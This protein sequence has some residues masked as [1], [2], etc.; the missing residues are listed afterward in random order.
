MRRAI[1]SLLAIGVL[2]ILG[3]GPAGAASPDVDLHTLRWFVHVDLIDAGAGRD[4]AFWQNAIDEAVTSGNKLLE[5]GQGPFDTECCTRINRTVAVSTFGSPG[6]GLDTVNSFAE[7]S[8]IA[9]LATSGSN[10]Y[11]VDSMTFCGSMGAPQSSPVGCAQ[12]PNCDGNGSDDPT[13]WM[14]VTVQSFDSSVLSAV[15]AHERGH[16]SCLDH[17]AANACQLMQASVTIPGL[18]GCLTT[19]ECSN[20]QAGRTTTSSGLTCGCHAMAGGIEDDGTSCTEVAGG[21]CSGGVCG[22]AT[23]DAGVKLLS[24]AAPGSAASGGTTDDAVQISGLP[25][26]WVTLGPFAPTGDEVK[27]MA[28]A[29]DADVLYGVVPT[30]ADDAIVTLDTATGAILATVGSIANGTDEI[31]SMAYDPGSTSATTDD[32]L[33]VLEV[34]IG[35][36]GEFRSIDPASPSTTT[37]LGPLPFSSANEFPGLAYDSQQGRLFA[38]SLFNSGLFEIDID[39]CTPFCTTTEVSG[40][41]SIF[42][43]RSSLAFSPDSGR[44]YLAGTSF[45]GTRTFV[46]AIDPVSFASPEA[47]SV[48]P[49][50]SEG[51]AALPL[52]EPGAPVGLLAGSLLLIGL[53]GRQGAGRRAR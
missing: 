36:N 22:S 11:L 7:Q 9:A 40:P 16:N 12:N 5:G 26:D 25:G 47:W 20:M 17:V 49:L 18:G 23:G 13:L 6:D 39:N 29:F 2:S 34:T 38:S 42:R 19:T 15:L 44:L 21:L 35:G 30:A 53:S 45:G 52:P 32:R 27:G 28:Y 41:N 8:A 33:L 51:L 1:Q 10:A 50:L 37:L 46:N 43:T 4:L 31:I 48:D 24:A 14:T 3:A